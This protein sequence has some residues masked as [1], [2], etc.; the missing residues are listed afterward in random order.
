MIVSPLHRPCLQ[1]PPSG[2]SGWQNLRIL[3]VLWALT[4]L[5][6]CG[7]VREQAAAWTGPNI[8]RAS[9]VKVE[10]TSWEIRNASTIQI[11][12]DPQRLAEDVRRTTRKVY[13]GVLDL[14]SQGII[15]HNGPDEPPPAEDVLL[16]NDLQGE[17]AAWQVGNSRVGVAIRIG[18]FG[19]QELEKRWLRK[20]IDVMN[21]PPMPK[22]YEYRL[23]HLP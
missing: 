19:N 22:R 8:G 15:D 18:F 17:V 14:K 12:G 7:T 2:Q 11:N 6:G 16:P 9:L 4:A 23:P 3:T 5:L 13:W 21:G 20:F 1:R 10:G